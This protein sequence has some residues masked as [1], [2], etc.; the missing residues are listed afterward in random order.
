VE[1]QIF[2]GSAALTL[3]PATVTSDFRE[4]DERLTHW[5]VSLSPNYKYHH[6]YSL[7]G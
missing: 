5:L 3:T 4:C 2:V 1:R 7:M 6:A